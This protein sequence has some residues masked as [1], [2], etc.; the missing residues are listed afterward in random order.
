MRVRILLLYVLLGSAKVPFVGGV[1]F[2]GSLP[3]LA[4][5]PCSVCAARDSVL[6][7]YTTYRCL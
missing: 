3:M 6:G 1:L 5:N 7:S 2:V 4:D